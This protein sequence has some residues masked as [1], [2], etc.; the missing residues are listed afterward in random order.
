MTY[1]PMRSDEQFRYQDPPLVSKRVW[2]GISA[3]ATAIL[4]DPAVQT[5][6]IG[7]LPTVVPVPYLPIATAVLAAA[8][9]LWSK[10]TDPRPVRSE[11]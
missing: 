11:D 9:A 10:R 6:L 4:V 1:D 8:L 5:A 2:A 7:A 3:G